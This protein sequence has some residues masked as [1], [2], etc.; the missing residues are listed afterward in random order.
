MNLHTTLHAA[1]RAALQPDP[2][3]GIPT[4]LIHQAYTNP[5]PPP[6]PETQ[7]VLYYFLTPEPEAPWREETLGTDG[8]PQV[9]SFSS[10]RL[11]LVF[12]GPHAASLAW[13]A[14]HALALDGRGNPRQLLRSSGVYLLPR[15]AGP[16]LT[17]EQWE[18]HHRPRADL[19]LPLRIA[20][21][22]SFPFDQGQV[23]QLPGILEEPSIIYH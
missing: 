4:P 6:P 17:W 21:N 10:W 8:H 19:S 12:Y 23:D 11:V 2:A 1:L 14:Y 13:R 20:R 9:F 22:E 3:S 15:A 18:T 16:T 7:D 5:S